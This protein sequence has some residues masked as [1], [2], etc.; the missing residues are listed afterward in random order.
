MPDAPHQMQLK[1]K[2]LDT[3]PAFNWQREFVVEAASEKI[4]KAAY[5]AQC[6]IEGHVPY[7]ILVF[8]TR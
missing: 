2:V 4:A 7:S 8:R 5:V 1:W 6:D 3:G